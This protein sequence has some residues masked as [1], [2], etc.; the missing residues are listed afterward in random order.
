MFFVIFKIL[1]QGL[2]ISFIEYS[3]WQ[4]EYILDWTLVEQLVG[5]TETSAIT[6]APLD[7]NCSYE[8]FNVA[9]GPILQFHTRVH[10]PC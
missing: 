1:L 7:I 2:L 6:E 5:Q 8:S 4:K 9:S 10:N 3:I